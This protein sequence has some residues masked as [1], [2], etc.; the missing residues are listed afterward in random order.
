MSRSDIADYL[1]LT[2]ETVCRYLAQLRRDGIVVI[3]R[4]GFE[5]RNPPALLELAHNCTQ[6]P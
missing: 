4:S 5:L 6:V 2:I 1:G 3:L